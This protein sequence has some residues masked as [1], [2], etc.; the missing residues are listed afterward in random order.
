MDDTKSFWNLFRRHRD[1]RQPSPENDKERSLREQLD[2]M[3]RN[4]IFFDFDSKNKISP[5]QSKFGG[6]PALPPKWKWPHYTTELGQEMALTFLLQINC[7]EL[8]PYDTDN[9]LPHEGMFYLFYDHINQPWLNGKGAK[10]LYTPTPAAE[11]CVVEFPDD[12]TDAQ[13]LH[14]MGLKFYNQR[15]APDWDDY[16]SLTGYDQNAHAYTDWDLIEQRLGSWG[17]PSVESAGR[18]LGYASLI[19]NGI[20]EAC[21]SRARGE[22][23]DSYSTESAREWILLLQLNSI[24]EPEVDISFGDCGSLYFYIRRHDLEHRDF[25]QIQ[26]EL[27][28]Y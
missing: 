18:M 9:L 17:Y 14:E 16:Y 4:G 11:L 24:E 1:T 25:S 3:A 21:E 20:A 5:L 8:A 7:E 27:Q 2:T 26:F 12:L 15:T 22:K 6:Q 13:R 23:P 28:C 19:Q 10:L